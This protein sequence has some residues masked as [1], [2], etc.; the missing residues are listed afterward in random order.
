[1]GLGLEEFQY[2]AY[3][4]GFPG[5]KR[6]LVITFGK[7]VRQGKETHRADDITDAHIIP[8]LCPFRD[9]K[10]PVPE[11]G[12]DGPLYEPLAGLIAPIKAFQK[13]IDELYLP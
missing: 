10:L 3:G 5:A 11:L 4:R 2:L 1:M 7:A 8:V 12:E 6:Y 13:D 9:G